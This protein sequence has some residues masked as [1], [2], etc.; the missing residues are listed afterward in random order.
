MSKDM[1]GAWLALGVAGAAT[2]A[3]VAL[4]GRGSMARGTTDFARLARDLA[5]LYFADGEF[6]YTLT[7]DGRVAGDVHVYS[8]KGAHGRQIIIEG[9]TGR[10]ALSSKATDEAR[11]AAHLEGFLAKTAEAAAPHGG[12]MA[13]ENVFKNGERVT[14]SMS[15]GGASRKAGRSGTVRGVTRH[16]SIGGPGIGARDTRLYKVEMDD[17]SVEHWWSGELAGVGGSR[18]KGPKLKHGYRIVGRTSGPNGNF[19]VYEAHQTFGPGSVYYV[20]S[21]DGDYEDLNPYGYDT[22]TEAMAA[23]RRKAGTKGSGSAAR[24]EDVN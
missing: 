18:A 2:A 6:T 17:G 23:A 15:Y 16:K 22:K 9:P 21:H 11:L 14:V 19:R 8:E 1:N 13:R 3:G 24:R 7:I 20:A 12:S 10:H 4:G 5:A